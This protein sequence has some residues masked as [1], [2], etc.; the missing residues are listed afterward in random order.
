MIILPEK[1]RDIMK[2]LSQVIGRVIKTWCVFLAL[3]LLTA[4]DV[5]T[6]HASMISKSPL[7]IAVSSVCLVVLAVVWLGLLWVGYHLKKLT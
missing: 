3:A 7:T 2:D 4:Y 1:D 6:L 5:I